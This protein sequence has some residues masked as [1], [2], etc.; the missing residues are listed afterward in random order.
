METRP[1]RES[2][3]HHIALIVSERSTCKRANV[4]AIL[5]KDKRIISTGYNG[6]PP[7]QP[8]CTHV[9]CERDGDR[10]GC[11]R[12]IHAEANAIAWAARAGV[13]TEGAEMY[14]TH[15]PC[16]ECAK[17]LI[18]AGIRTLHF[19]EYYRDDRGIQLLKNSGVAVSAYSYRD[20][21]SSHFK[22]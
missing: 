21:A 6:A 17:L 14:C 15:S 20:T 8:H 2:T 18:S 1:S 7:R 13:L 5:V 10:G 16:Y 9:G 3:F 4:G 11:S 12:T 22:S 19:N